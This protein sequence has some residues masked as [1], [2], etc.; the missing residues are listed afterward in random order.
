MMKQIV[1]MMVR[2]DDLFD[3][4]IDVITG[5]LLFIVTV[6]LL[7]TVIGSTYIFFSL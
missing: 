5:C 4:V 7:F 2:C 1:K 3:K 6:G